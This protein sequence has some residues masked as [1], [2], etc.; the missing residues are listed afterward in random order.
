MFVTDSRLPDVDHIFEAIHR[1][2]LVVPTARRVVAAHWD[3]FIHDGPGAAGRHGQGQVRRLPADAARPAGRGVPQRHHR[4]ALRLDLD[5][6]PARGGQRQGHLAGP[7]RAHHGDPRLPRP[8]GHAEQGLRPRRPAAR[9]VHGRV[10]SRSSA[11]TSLQ[12]PGRLVAGPRRHPGD[13][14]ARR[15]ALDLPADRGRGLDEVVDLV[16]IGAGPAG[17]AAAVYAASEGLSRR[18]ARGR[19]DRRPGRH[20][21]DDPQL[22]RLPARHLRHAAGDAGPQPGAAVRH[23]FLHRLG[24]HRAR[25]RRRRRAAPGPHRRRRRPRPHRA[26]R[27][28]GRLPQARRARRS[29]SWSAPASTTAPR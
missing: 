13:L 3:Y 9:G 18:R 26:R 27:R 19:G 7:R 21:L 22:P 4:P 10:R 17:L 14:G 1:W 23:D 8:D 25:G 24:G 16:V 6:R 20:Q 28:R 2:R 5:G 15:R 29:R 11:P 12:L